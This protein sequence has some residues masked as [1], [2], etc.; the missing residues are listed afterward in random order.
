[1]VGEAQD[2]V[3]AVENQDPMP[4]VIL[5]CQ[6]ATAWAVIEATRQIKRNSPHGHRGL[7]MYE[8]QQ[9]IFDPS[10]SGA[11]AICSRTRN[12]ANRRTSGRSIGER[13]AHPPVSRQQ[14]SRV[15][16]HVTEEGKAGGVEHDP[17]ERE[18][19]V[20]RLV[21]DGKTNKPEV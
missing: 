8:E 13:I 1:M 18:I 17:T 9:Y 6:Y 16:P 12:P 3:E 7:T 4:D 15:P 20:L 10:E 5:I 11:T 14:N 19:T 2:G 21:A